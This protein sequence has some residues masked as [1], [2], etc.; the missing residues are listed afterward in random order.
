V[1]LEHAE[2]SALSYAGAGFL[3]DGD[4]P[5]VARRAAPRLGEHN[6]DLYVKALGLT[7]EAPAVILTDCWR[8]LSRAGVF[9]SRLSVRHTFPESR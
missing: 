7:P 3:M 9:N 6:M 5:I 1:P 8:D 2:V 4:N